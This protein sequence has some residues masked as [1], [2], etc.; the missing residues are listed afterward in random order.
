[1]RHNPPSWR[2]LLAGIAVSIL[3]T[4]CGGSGSDSSTTTPGTSKLA[5]SG[6]PSQSAMVGQTYKMQPTVTN[7]DGTVAFSASNLPAWLT[8]NTSSGMV[9]GTP[10]MADV[11]TD[12]GITISASA[13]GESASLSP[14]SITVAQTAPTSGSASI[15]W[16]IPTQNTDGTPLTDLAG[17][18]VMYGTSPVELTQTVTVSDPTS[19]SYVLNNL[20]SGTWYFAVVS[21]N[22]AGVESSPTNVASKTI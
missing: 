19:T 1:M 10:T 20:S 21:V 11:G 2:A 22:S 18:K 3:I 15:T 16:T 6:A 13:G 14:F 4:A 5:I 7:A 9:T 8:L 12:S 17:F